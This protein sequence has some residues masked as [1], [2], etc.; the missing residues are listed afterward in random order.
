MMIGIDTNVLVRHVMQDDLVQAD[1]AR[2]LFATLSADTPGFIPLVV[3]AELSWVL[4]RR[5]KL[6]RT[7]VSRVIE[8][9]LLSSNLILERSELALEAFRTYRSRN[10]DFADCLILQCAEDAGCSQTYTFDTNAAKSSGMTLL[11]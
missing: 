8:G 1:M 11:K 9:L 10:A 7:Q 3:L 6:D 2:Q 4:S 5:Y